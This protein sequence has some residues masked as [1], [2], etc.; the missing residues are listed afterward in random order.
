MA[1]L[2]ATSGSLQ[3]GVPRTTTTVTA[4]TA[5]V[6]P[7]T[8]VQLHLH[9]SEK[10]FFA[11]LGTLEDWK[12][13]GTFTTLCGTHTGVQVGAPAVIVVVRGSLPH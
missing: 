6:P 3:L 12:S 9:L 10:M 4:A 7:L 2:E 11:S 13:S 5:P 1:V 8:L